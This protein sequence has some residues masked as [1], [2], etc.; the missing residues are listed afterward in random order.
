LTRLEELLPRRDIPKER[1]KDK[2]SELAE[3]VASIQTELDKQEDI[4]SSI[5]V[6]EE[7]RRFLLNNPFYLFGDGPVAS[8]I[9]THALFAPHKYLSPELQDQLDWITPEKRQGFYRRMNLH[10]TV[11]GDGDRRGDRWEPCC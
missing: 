8:W 5:Q 2:R 3:G 1:Y 4:E 6:A 10:V 7:S 9:T 11:G